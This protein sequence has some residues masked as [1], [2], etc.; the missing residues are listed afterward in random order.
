MGVTGTTHQMPRRRA[1]RYR[2]G[3]RIAARRRAAGLSQAQL[4][5][6]LPGTVEGSQISRWETGTSFPTY[7]NIVVLA[8][9]LK[10]SEEDLLCERA[11]ES[12]SRGR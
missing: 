9:A 4:G 11:P 2:V 12:C 1:F 8:R 6:R 7:K 10:C 3:E 5:R